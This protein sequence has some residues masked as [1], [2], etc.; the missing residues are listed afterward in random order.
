[1]AVHGVPL[2]VVPRGADQFANASRVESLGAGI[3]LPTER[4]TADSMHAAI[5]SLLHESGY[6]VAAQ[7][8]ADDTARLPSGESA[9]DYLETI[10]GA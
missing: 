1:L 2:V 10:A 8:I 3:M 7:R 6:R 4:Q 9:V 5:T